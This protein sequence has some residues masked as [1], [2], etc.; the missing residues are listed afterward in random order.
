MTEIVPIQPVLPVEG[1]WTQA[2]LSYVDDEP[3]GL[4][5][6]NQD[7]N[8]GLQR[9]I[10]SK[11]QQDL[12]NQLNIIYS[13]LFIATSSEYLD[14]WESQLGLP[15]APPGVSDANRRTRV[16][17][18]LK[19]GA[20]TDA[21]RASVIEPFLT[22]TFGDVVKLVPEGISVDAA[23]I[24][25]Y[26]EPADISNI[27]RV[28][29]DITGFSYQVWI[30][31]TNTPD[32]AS[33]TRE[34]QRITPAG[35]TFTIDNSKTNILNYHRTIIHDGPS[36][37]YRLGG[38][39]ADAGSLGLTGTINS[40]PASLAAPGLLHAAVD[41]DLA[42]AGNAA[43]DFDGVDDWI[44][45]PDNPAISS[46][47][48]LSV[49]AWVR[50]DI[51]DGSIRTVFRKGPSNYLLNVSGNV[52]QFGVWKNTVFASAISQT[53]LAAGVTYHLVGTFD[54]I[55]LC[56]YVNGVLERDAITPVGPIDYTANLGY[57]GANAGVGGFWNGGID[58]VAIYSYPLPPEII[59]RHY[60]TGRNVL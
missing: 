29:D 12:I 1:Q 5:P 13:E 60:N 34:L 22:A 21:L 28:Y 59:L 3:P 54:G 19:K 49:E 40:A 36:V 9:R 30:P 8:W 41:D 52:A 46:A 24:P 17:A 27:Y 32:I 2:E 42:G 11:Q 55:K 23:G 10:F 33:L 48:G 39:A 57:I 20:F 58:E 50:P 4:F 6:E 44:S 51:A 37:Y 53:S 25:L 16:A 7:S 45:I 15:I 47:Y 43:Y 31:S 38:S 56:L 14:V 18:R 26:G 35:I